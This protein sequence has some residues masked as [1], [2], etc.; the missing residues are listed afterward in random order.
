MIFPAEDPRV[1]RV[2]RKVIRG[3]CAYYR[4]MPSVS[5]GQVCAGLASMLPQPLREA[6]EDGGNW[7]EIYREEPDVIE[8]GYATECPEP[9][10][11]IWSAV[12]L[13]KVA[14]WGV[15]LYPD[16]SLDLSVLATAERA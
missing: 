12:F 2:V 13:G 10:H 7:M 1:M 3:L 14:F 8:Y 5:D 15:V 9:V 11:S 6:Y 4:L 16:H